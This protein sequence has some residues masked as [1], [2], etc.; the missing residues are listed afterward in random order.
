M[1]RDSGFTLIE[2]LVVMGIIVVLVGLLIPGIR[3]ARRSARITQATSVILNL[4]T[5]LSSYNLD[6]GDYP[7]SR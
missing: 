3:I 1:R 4:E 5:G 6:F 7:P 2:L